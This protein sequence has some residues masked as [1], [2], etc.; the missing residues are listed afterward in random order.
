[1]KN[2]QI[3]PQRKKSAKRGFVILCV[4]IIFAVSLFYIIRVVV[5]SYISCRVIVISPFFRNS[6]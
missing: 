4:L 5:Y 6:N 1:M 3:K 2:Q